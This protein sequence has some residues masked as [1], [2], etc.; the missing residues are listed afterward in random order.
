VIDHL[1]FRVRDLRVAR[2]FYE[3][4]TRPLGLVVIN[5]TETSFLVGRSAERPIPFLWIGTDQPDFWTASHLTSASPIHLAFQ[6]ADRVSVEAF[7]AAA[8][9]NGG[10]DNGQP[11]PR[12]PE[13]L[14]YYA[15]FALDPDG[16]NIEAGYRG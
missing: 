8:L 6:A 2:R 5:N 12:G 14:K 11:G 1:G 4:V 9:A 7:H 16:N 10:T 15:A 13:E 3:A